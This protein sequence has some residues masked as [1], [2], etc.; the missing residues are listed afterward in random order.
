MPVYENSTPVG[1]YYGE[2]GNQQSDMYQEIM[3]RAAEN[4]DP[5]RQAEQDA[6][7]QRSRNFWTG[8]NLFANVV[9]N[10]INVNGTANNAPNMTWND[11]AS[12]K[13]YDTW[14]T[15]D[16]QLKADR[17]AAAQ[18]LDAL[19]MEDAKLR[20][21][22][23]EKRAAEQQDANKMNFNI[24]L[25]NARYERGKADE[26]EKW[27]RNQQ[28][29]KEAADLSFERQ[30]ELA[31]MRGTRRGGGG[32]S[33]SASGTKTPSVGKNSIVSGGITMNVN[34]KADR[35]TMYKSMYN[36]MERWIKEHPEAMPEG[37]KMPTD[38]YGKRKFVD[39][40]FGDL[41]KDNPDF[42]D[43]MQGY[44]GDLLIFDEEPAVGAGGYSAVQTLPWSDDFTKRLNE[45]GVNTVTQT[46]DWKRQAPTR[47]NV[48]N[49][50]GGY[51]IGSKANTRN[52]RPDV[53]YTVRDKRGYDESERAVEG[54]GNAFL[55]RNPV[56]ENGRFIGTERPAHKLTEAEKKAIEQNGEKPVFLDYLN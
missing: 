2:Q 40:H 49:Q 1:T 47:R 11:A 54:G 15:A 10:A 36:E 12:Q 48:Q 46:P 28:A 37:V 52:W 38:E 9:A 27:E 31:R 4:A 5:A 53:T 23:A 8:A 33:K 26:Q 6:R 41:C 21:A 56:D 14:R 35:D 43:E 24:A 39:D 18:R 30:K 3:R 55:S 44:Y 45:I 32:G 25:E 42:M 51:F 13:M 19:Q 17:K 50:D 22:G 20:A 7:I 29:A 34:T 16:Q